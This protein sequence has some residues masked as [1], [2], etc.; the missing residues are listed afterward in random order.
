M[1]IEK[2]IMDR[3]TKY[4]IRGE[5]H[6]RADK[7]GRGGGGEWE[8]EKL[9]MSEE[10]CGWEKRRG[11]GMESLVRHR[12]WENGIVRRTGPIVRLSRSLGE[13]NR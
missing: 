8:T 9:E 5:S 11:L 7:H 4:Q 3:Q 1:W 10:E 12:S 13:R 2:E 6:R